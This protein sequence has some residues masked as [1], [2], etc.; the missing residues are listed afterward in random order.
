MPGTR[1]GV[2]DVAESAV[3]GIC[4]LSQYDKMF[5]CPVITLPRAGKPSWTSLQM[6]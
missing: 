5:P 3:L 6:K 2:T 4:A 1:P